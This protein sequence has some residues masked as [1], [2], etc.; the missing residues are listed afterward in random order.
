MFMR[1][2][3]L[4]KSA[5][6]VFRQAISGPTRCRVAMC[7]ATSPRR[8]GSIARG[9]SGSAEI[10]SVAPP[11]S[12]A[13]DAIAA[14]PGDHVWTNSSVRKTDT[15]GVR[16]PLP[17]LLQ[18]LVQESALAHELTLWVGVEVLERI[19]EHARKPLAREVELA[20]PGG[21]ADT[22]KKSIEVIRGPVRRGSGRHAVV[23]HTERTGEAGHRLGIAGAQPAHDGA[24]ERAIRF[25]LPDVRKADEKRG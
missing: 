21:H 16:R 15:P 19:F 3:F 5:C 4:A 17:R 12:H 18:H 13:P 10:Q 2:G 24:G 25:P 7:A 11:P 6:K 14:E 20:Q 23:P 22:G 1:L 9:A 8:A